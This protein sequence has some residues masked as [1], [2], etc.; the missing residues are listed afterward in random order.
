M[1]VNE[2]GTLTEDTIASFKND[3]ERALETME[4]DGEVSAFGITINPAQ[5]VLSTSRLSITIKVVPVGVARNIVV[6]VG[7]AVRITNN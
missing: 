5:N 2:D 3:A 7:F 6:N 1:Y 4:R